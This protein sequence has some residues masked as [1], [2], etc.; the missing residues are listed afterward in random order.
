[1]PGHGHIGPLPDASVVLPLVPQDCP[2]LFFR[3]FDNL[4]LA[5]LMCEVCPSRAESCPEARNEDWNH[6]ERAPDKHARR[7][8][9]S[10]GI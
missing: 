3:A 6:H 7:H 1:M 9:R 8:P 10:W 2:I 5:R 4:F